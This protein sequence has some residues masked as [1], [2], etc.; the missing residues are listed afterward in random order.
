MCLLF[1]TSILVKMTLSPL[2]SFFSQVDTFRIVL[3]KQTEF[4]T[5]NLSYS[6]YSQKN[7]TIIQ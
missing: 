4:D 7:V 2:I 6:L 1:L 5:L 3:S